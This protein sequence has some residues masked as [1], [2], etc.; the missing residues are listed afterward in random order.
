ME[1]LRGAI[2]VYAVADEDME[3]ETE[4]R[5]RQCIFC[6]LNS[7]PHDRIVASQLRLLEHGDQPLRLWGTTRAGDPGCARLIDE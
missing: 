2:A 5:Q 1:E 6:V 4:R 3:R 7:S